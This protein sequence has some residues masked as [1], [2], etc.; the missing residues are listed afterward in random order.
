MR[1]CIYEGIPQVDCFW[2]R[3]PRLS[4][5][6]F[7]T[8]SPVSLWQIQLSVPPFTVPLPVPSWLNTRVGGLRTDRPQPGE[9]T[10]DALFVQDGIAI[11][12]PL[13]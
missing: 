13:S 11:S 6:Q 2:H 12:L 10:L 1:T 5:G 3:L 8:W 7:E 9:F 4:Y